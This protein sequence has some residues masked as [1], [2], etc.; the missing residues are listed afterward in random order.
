[1]PGA[2]RLKDKAQVPSDSHACPKCP[3]NA[4]GPATAGSPNV[5]INGLPAL[6]VGDPGVHS[7]CCGANTWQAQTGSSTVFVNS[8]L[9]NGIKISSRSTC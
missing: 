2:S 5:D 8:V 3:H 4:V 9:V 6:R 7:S 1:M